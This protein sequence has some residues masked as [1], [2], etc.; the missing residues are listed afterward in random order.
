MLL[1]AIVSLALVTACGADS[2]ET[3]KSDKGNNNTEANND[4]N[5]EKEEITI[6][7]AHQWGED[8]FWDGIG[9]DLDE[10]FPHITI[11]VQEAG[12]D[13]PEDLERLIAAKDSP[14][15]VTLGL[16]T[17][18]NFMDDLG[19]AY[20]MDELIESADFDLD[21][22]EPS[23]V[24]YARKQDPND[25]MGLYVMPNARPTYSL[26]YNKDVFDLL[27]VDYPE[28]GITWEESIELAKKLS[29][30]MNGVQYRG[31]DLDVPYDAF[32][33]FDAISVDPETDE[34]IVAQSEAYKRYLQMIEDVVN[35]P[36]N[37]PDD[38]PA[39]LLHNWGSLFSEGEIA[40]APAATNW[41]WVEED[42]VDIVT[43]PVWEG[44]EG[45]NPVPNGGGY[46]ITE[47][48]EHKEEV[49]KIVEYLLSDEYQ[50]ERSKEGQASVLVSE[51]VN[52]AF[53]SDNPK[54]TGKNLES[55]FLNEYATGPEK[56]SKY[57]V[58]GL[59]TAP[60]DFIESGQ[61]VNEFLRVF[62]E[63]GEEYVRETKAQ[64]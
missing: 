11:E 19:L 14:D 46:A 13:H 55:L 2:N 54:R 10:K 48:S 5:E 45:L 64:E 29:R 18:M 57:G 44:R 60:I 9:K 17:H 30:E 27:G 36:G 28:D 35:I 32:M 47:P 40:M 4:G 24:E 51:E 63:Q 41:G 58:P 39:S 20:N 26:H 15:I 3:S 50:L 7:W 25:E 23:I 52:D 42:N 31:L 59:W 12:T 22:L 43:Y 61:D 8:H 6:K 33:Q 62:Q 49:F 56:T 53:A 38:D 21:R 1:V 37:Y 16:V 34:V